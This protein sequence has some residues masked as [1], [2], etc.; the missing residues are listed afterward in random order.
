MLDKEYQLAVKALAETTHRWNIEWKQACDK[1]QDLEEE[2]IDFLKS[3]LWTLAN[4]M[5]TVCV[6][7]DESCERIRMTLEKCEVE[8]VIQAFIQA[9]GTGQEIPGTLHYHI[10]ERQWLMVDPPKYKNFYRQ[11]ESDDD[12]GYKVA[13]FS[14]DTNPQ[15]RSSTSTFGASDDEGMRPMTGMSMRHEEPAARPMTGM[16]I[17]QE[18]IAMRPTTGMAMPLEEPPLR[19]ATGI[20]R[21]EETIMRPTNGMPSQIDSPMRPATGIPQSIRPPTGISPTRPSTGLPR[22]ESP[23]RPMTGIPPQRGRPATMAGI[24]DES[25]PS[26]HRSRS[27]GGSQSPLKAVINEY[28][29]EGITQFCRQDSGSRHH[30]RSQSRRSSVSST[31]SASEAISHSSS[32]SSLQLNTPVRQASVPYQPKVLQRRERSETNASNGSAISPTKKSHSFWN[33]GAKSPK[34]GANGSA[35][36]SPSKNTTPIS[37]MKGSK[38][39]PTGM[40]MAV[41]S[42]DVGGGNKRDTFG[43]FSKSRNESEEPIA[44]NSSVMLNIGNNVLEVNNPDTKAGMRDRGEDKFRSSKDEVDPLVAALEDLKMVSK[45]PRMSPSKRSPQMD[46]P[47]AVEHQHQRTESRMDSAYGN[48]PASRQDYN[49]SSSMRSSTSQNIRQSQTPPSRGGQVQ[50]Q[51]GSTPPPGHDARRNTLGAPPPAHSAAEMERT[52]RQYA[53]QVHQVLGGGAPTGR[54]ATSSQM[55]PRSTSPRPGSR[56]SQYGGDDSYNGRPPSSMSMHHQEMPPRSRSPAPMRQDMPRSRSPAPMQ[57][58]RS[59][60]PPQEYAR[61]PSRE[62]RR[63]SGSLEPV[64][65]QRPPYDDPIRRSPSP[66]PYPRATSPAPRSARP[67]SSAA[68]SA[69][70]PFGISMDKYGNVLDSTRSTPPSNRPSSRADY[71]YGSSHRHDLIDEV[72]SNRYAPPSANPASRARSKSQSDVR[73]GKFTEDGKP[74]LFVA[75]AQYDY[76]AAIPQECSFRKGDLVQVTRTQDDGWWEAE[77]MG[78]RPVMQGLVPRYPFPSHNFQHQLMCSNFFKMVQ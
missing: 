35:G 34:Q 44:H 38:S 70:N 52:R 76:N 64:P 14:R 62:D 58:S 17:R 61:A 25:P 23:T 5:S 8:E 77:V 75:K 7:D 49:S 6:A 16:S 53:S 42:L 51:T 31:Y 72:S 68:P 65:Y 54:P 11:E 60:A 63:R 55:P 46:N 39:V 50:G 69:S 33:F 24:Q 22:Q 73:R 66:G 10:I 13:Q 47:Y 3:N 21:H 12:T 48:R 2:R 67:M 57:R 9:K 40:A 30:N 43:G 45:T 26:S 37:P 4:I 59:P 41:P 36:N 32:E 20:P 19:P 27:R 71:A 15:Y 56:Q 18:E 28:P 1:Y 78:T 74:V 29:P